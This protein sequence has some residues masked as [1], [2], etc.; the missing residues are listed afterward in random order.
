V[1]TF[2]HKMA[3]VRLFGRAQDTAD[4]APEVGTVDGRSGCGV[5]WTW[6]QEMLLSKDRLALLRQLVRLRAGSSQRVLI[7]DS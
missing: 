7:L 4:I 3:K 5:K 6:T 1:S 2:A